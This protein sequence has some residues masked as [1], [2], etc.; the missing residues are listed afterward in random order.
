MLAGDAH[1]EVRN[2]GTPLPIELNQRIFEPFFR[3]DDN[4][5]Q[6]GTGIGLSISKALAELHKG[7]I[8]LL[9]YV[10]GFN[11]FALTLPVHQLIEFNLSG[12]WKKH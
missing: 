8:E 4:G 10:N 2:D 3:V 9:G 12:K 6:P 7:R 11:I 5:K 1:V